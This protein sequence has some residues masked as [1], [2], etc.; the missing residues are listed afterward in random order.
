MTVYSAESVMKM[1]LNW[2]VSMLD[3]PTRPGADSPSFSRMKNSLKKNWASCGRN[4]DRDSGALLFRQRQP[5]PQETGG[6]VS[7]GSKAKRCEMGRTGTKASPAEGYDRAREKFQR[8][9]KPTTLS[10]RAMRRRESPNVWPTVR[11]RSYPKESGSARVF[12]SYKFGLGRGML[13]QR[14]IP[15]LSG[16][17][18]SDLNMR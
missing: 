2:R 8:T 13:L 7:D 17:V 15:E 14:I 5:R 9:P 10:E 16:A 12:S 18:Q 1:P 11:K 6:G 3:S 4:R